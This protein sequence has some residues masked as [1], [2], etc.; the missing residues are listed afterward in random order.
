MKR[1]NIILLLLGL[2]A[3]AYIL[4]RMD[5]DIARVIESV[6]SPIYIVLAALIYIAIP[7]INALRMKLIIFP[8]ERKMLPIR[9]LFMIEYIYKFLSNVMPFKLNIPAKALL[10]NKKCGLK[11]SSGASAVSF[12]Y[13][14]DS[15]IT[16]FF[17]FLGVIAYFRDDPRISLIS[18]QYFILIALAGIVIFFSIPAHYFEI[19]LLYSETFRIKILQKIAVFLVKVTTAI[20]VTWARILLD[21]KMFSVLLTTIL[22]WGAAILGTM[23]LFMSTNNYVPPTWILVV[24]SVGIFMGGISTIPGGLGV[25]EA[26]MVVMYSALGVSTEASVA[27][28]LMGR[29]M[30]FL[31]VLIGY[32]V[33]VR[34]GTELLEEK[35]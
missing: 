33:S 2:G 19:A 26:T 28:V 15:G 5:V 18:I 30:T 4:A 29:L 9:D 1:K 24:M 14:L 21:R 22:I 25:R 17:G 35:E 32:V 8:I 6:K 16:I 20:R 11:L 7:F 13:A 10:L 27:N 34:A 12:E 23:L 31:P 3:L